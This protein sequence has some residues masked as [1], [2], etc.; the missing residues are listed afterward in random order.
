VTSKPAS[1]RPRRPRR[2]W[3]RLRIAALAFLARWLYGL[4]RATIRPVIAEEEAREVY[5][6]FERNERVIIAFWHGQLTMMQ[7]AYR[8]KAAGICIQVSQHGDGEIIARAV[9]PYGIRTA[10]GSASRGAIS[11][12]RSM[13]V[14]FRDGCDLAIAA[15]GPRGPYHRAN[16]GAIHLAEAT[17][18]RIFPIAASPRRALVFGSWDRFFVPMPFT[19]VHYTRGESMAV[20]K[21]IDAATRDRL[22]DRLEDELN[23]ASAEA[24]RRAGR[25]WKPRRK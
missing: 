15:D 14:A 16:V 3:A 17:G 7:A 24:D 13:L 20:G 23:R 9:R 21:D 11:S 1:A 18:A 19:R 12:L 25:V 10:R 2:P 8:G 5:A 22:R 4:V 6:A